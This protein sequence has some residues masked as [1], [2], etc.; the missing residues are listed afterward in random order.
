MIIT[1]ICALVCSSVGLYFVHRFSRM[2][3]LENQ[4]E[5]LFS[6]QRV[7]I[8]HCYRLVDCFPSY[9]SGPC[10]DCERIHSPIDFISIFTLVKPCN[11]RS[12]ILSLVSEL[13]IFG[14]LYL[15]LNKYGLNAMYL[16]YMFMVFIFFIIT[17]VDYRYYIIPDELNFLGVVCGFCLSVIISLAI[18]TNLI[19]NEGFFEGLHGFTITNSFF[20]IVLSTGILLSIA[21]LTSTYLGRDAMGGGDIKLTAFIGAFLGYKATLIALALSSVLGSLFGIISMFKSKLIQKNQGYTMIAFGPYIIM[22]TLIVMYFGDDQIIKYYERLS[23]RWIHGY[24][25]P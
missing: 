1:F 19:S 14:L 12:F 23:M 9:K 18:S 3:L 16:I 8:P 6:Q 15:F 25:L 24:I 10:Q 21:Y 4:L 22:A 5:V 11:E 13:S 20:G 2:A 17:I 7:S